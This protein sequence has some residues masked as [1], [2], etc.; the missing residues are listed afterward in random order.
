MTVTGCRMGLVEVSMLEQSKSDFNLL[1]RCIQ[2]NR[3]FRMCI[4]AADCYHQLKHWKK[5]QWDNLRK[6][7]LDA[8]YLSES[9]ALDRHMSKNVEQSH[10]FVGNC[11]S[12]FMRRFDITE[13]LDSFDDLLKSAHVW[14]D[15]YDQREEMR[16]LARYRTM[17]K[18]KRSDSDEVEADIIAISSD[19]E[20]EEESDVD[21]KHGESL[22]LTE[23][24]DDKE[25]KDIKPEKDKV[26]LV[27]NHRQRIELGGKVFTRETLRTNQYLLKQ[28]ARK[29]IEEDQ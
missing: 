20:D 13:R 11:L 2:L 5:T 22:F 10:T 19:D 17:E 27:D 8:G 16:I 15:R 28:D 21:L 1:F 7:C 12:D 4:K 24:D 26:K 6:L 18:R 14:I 3:E 29:P 23:G 9:V 25:E